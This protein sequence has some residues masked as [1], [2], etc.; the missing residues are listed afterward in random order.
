MGFTS[1]REVVDGR[2]RQPRRSLRA[3]R[4]PLDARFLALRVYI[5]YPLH[6]ASDEDSS[7]RKNSDRRSSVICARTHFTPMRPTYAN[8]VF[9]RS[10]RSDLNRAALTLFPM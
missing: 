6:R 7:R 9:F 2:W 10:I 8:S 4:L 1:W 3:C 5:V